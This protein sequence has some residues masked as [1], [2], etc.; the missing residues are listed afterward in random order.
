[1]AKAI[2]V[3]ATR[4]GETKQIGELIAKIG[5]HIMEFLG[6]PV[7]QKGSSAKAQ[8]CRLVL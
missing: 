7:F 1:M 5:G 2:I 4:T 6:S 3:Y 8:R